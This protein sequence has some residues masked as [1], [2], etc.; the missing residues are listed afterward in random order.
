MNTELLNQLNGHFTDLIPPHDYG[1]INVED[2][3]STFTSFGAADDFS[4]PFGKY[5]YAFADEA[6]DLPLPM[7]CLPLVEEM[8][9]EGF[10]DCHHVLIWKLEPL[11]GPICG[12][13]C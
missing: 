13:P 8:Y 4:L 2:T 11:N 7:F 10:V 12:L 3:N 6:R 5:F 1:V 9:D